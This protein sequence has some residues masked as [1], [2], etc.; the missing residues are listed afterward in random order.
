MIL[1]AVMGP[2]QDIWS[3]GCHVFELLASSM[4]FSVLSPHVW[5][6]HE[7][8]ESGREQDDEELWTE[9][10]DAH[11]LDIAKL[12]GP[13]PPS[14]MS[15]FPRSKTYFNKDGEIIKDYVGEPLSDDETADGFQMPRM[16]DSIEDYLDQEKG[17]DLCSEEAQIVKKLLRT[18]LKLEPT[19]RPTVEELLA[20][21]WFSDPTPPRQKSAHDHDCQRTI[22]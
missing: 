13:V 14:F 3:F 1:G 4:L 7:P 16:P 15:R 12:L 22:H 10:N 20:D 6:K 19:D 11:I 2:P 18:I 8:L 5:G 9:T 21:P 17:T